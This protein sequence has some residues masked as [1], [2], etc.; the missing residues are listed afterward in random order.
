MGAASQRKG[1]RGEIELS[2]LLN[3]RGYHTRPGE[4]VSFGAEPDIVGLPG[5]HCELKRREAV[6]VAA[7]LRQAREDAEYFGGI[8]VLFC[9]GNHEAWRVTMT[10]EDWLK[11]Y[12]LSG[13]DMEDAE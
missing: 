4:P 1:R 8:P 6:D 11:L 2:R 7:A 10:L 5:I 9:R 12:Q 3:A 13:L